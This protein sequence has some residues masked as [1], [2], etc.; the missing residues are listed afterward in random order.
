MGT[1][2]HAP[3]AGALHGGARAGRRV[4]GRRRPRRS[5]A[6]SSTSSRRTAASSRRSSTTATSS[7]TRRR[8]SWVPRA[9]RSRRS[10]RPRFPRGGRRQYIANPGA[11]AGR[12]GMGDGAGWG[13]LALRSRAHR[14]GVEPRAVPLGEHQLQPG[15]TSASE[16]CSRPVY[17][18]LRN[19]MEIPETQIED[20]KECFFFCK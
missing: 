7:R 13:A 4:R 3:H 11:S 19:V 14:P 1:P 20:F 9:R 17:C 2:P 8:R 12:A 5:A 16:R 15:D 10:A 18:N 6:G